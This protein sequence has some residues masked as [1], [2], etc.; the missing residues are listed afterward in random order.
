MLTGVSEASL[1]SLI[2]TRD[3]SSFWKGG[4]LH[5]SIEGL[6]STMVYGTSKDTL[7]HLVQMAH[8]T[9]CSKDDVCLVAPNPEKSWWKVCSFD[10]DS[11]TIVVAP[12]EGF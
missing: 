3:L 12:F 8:H 1:D 2:G 9:L 5:V 4:S 6:G 7:C 10:P 11:G